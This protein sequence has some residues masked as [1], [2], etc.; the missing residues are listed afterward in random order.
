MTR[1]HS[2]DCMLWAKNL[3]DEFAKLKERLAEFVQKAEKRDANVKELQEHASDIATIK[4]DFDQLKKRVKDI[5]ELEEGNDED[6]RDMVDRIEKHGKSLEDLMGKMSLAQKE[7]DK[8]SQDI[9]GLQTA[10]SCLKT[11]MFKLEEKLDRNE[12]AV[13]K[14]E[15]KLKNNG[16]TGLAKKNDFSDPKT[17]GHHLKNV[18]KSQYEE[19]SMIQTLQA[20]VDELEHM[21]KSQQQVGMA[22][23]VA[24][25]SMVDASSSPVV[26]V[27]SSPLQARSTVPPA[28]TPVRPQPS[29]EMAS[30]ANSGKKRKAG[31]AQTE[32]QT[33]RRRRR[34]TISQPYELLPLGVSDD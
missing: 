12:T 3:K 17:L 4:H 19:Q 1:P 13:M 14:L 33:R 26:Q 34:R 18:M 24:T 2:P 30:K 21:L 16:H 22:S 6:I 7:N 15:E 28:Q 9:E 27:S 23:V 11:A 25:T 31:V 5:K 8:L 10:C 29:E 32:G 20:R